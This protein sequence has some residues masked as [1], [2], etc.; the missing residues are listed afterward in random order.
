MLSRPKLTTTAIASGAAAL[1]LLGMTG[2][3]HPAPPP[4]NA[5]PKV[6]YSET[7]DREIKEIMDLAGQ[8][9]WEDAHARADALYRQDPNN[10]LLARV[11]SWVDQQAQ[12][13]RSQALE[14]K[15]RSI[16]AKNSGFNPTL[17]SVLTEQKDRGLPP[18]KDVRD[19][20]DRIE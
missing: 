11:H 17:K 1:L 8:G 3:Q 16:D 4:P 12:T 6:T 18:R 13:Q 10:Q 15:I 2:C 20:I 19:A 9:R 14:D 5:P 7:Y